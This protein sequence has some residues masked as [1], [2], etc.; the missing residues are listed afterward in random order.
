MAM[1]TLPLCRRRVIGLGAGAL[2]LILA[3]GLLRQ[4]DADGRPL[5]EGDAYAPWR[6]WDDPSLRSTP[7]ALVAAAALAANPHD[8]QPWLFRVRDDAIEVIADLARNLGTMDPYVREMHLGLGCAIENMQAAAGPNGY[9][10]DVEVVG[11]ALTDLVERQRPAL[12]ALVRLVRRAPTAPDAR[13][14]AI[15][16]RHTNRYAYERGKAPPADWL[17]FARSGDAEAGVRAILFQEGAERGKFETAVVEATEAV[18][19]DATMIG[20]SDR[21]FRNSRAEIEAHRDGPTLD[22]AGLSFLTLTFARLFPVSAETSHSAWLS[23][24]RDV[25]LASAPVT[26][27][28]AVRDRYDRK[29]TIAAGRFWQRLHLSAVASDLA[30]QPLNQPIEMIDRERQTGRGSQW[31]KRIAELTGEDWQATFS[32]RA[33]FSSQSAPPSPRRR[34]ADVVTG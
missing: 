34:L 31:S 29:A 12:A 18:I 21:W 30:L 11:G 13:Y 10:A 9:R 33:G 1:D 25:Q 14:R 24:T 2:T 28:I 16:E 19:A 32:F 8:T 17:E 3:G 6:L 26:G 7:V 20:D 5:P 15:P 22:A 23:Q 27:L 4:A